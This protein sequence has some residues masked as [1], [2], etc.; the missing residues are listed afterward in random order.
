MSINK[1]KFFLN[2]I[3]LESE[4]NILIFE[5]IDQNNLKKFLISFKNLPEIEN[6]CDKSKSKLMEEKLEIFPEI[7]KIIRFDINKFD[8]LVES[9]LKNEINDCKLRYKFLFIHIITYISNKKYEHFN[10]ITI[11]NKKKV[12]E[13]FD[14]RDERRYFGKYVMEK[15][16]KLFF[17]KVNLNFKIKHPKNF[18]SE[19]ENSK[20]LDLKLCVPL[21]LLYGYLKVKYSLNLEEVVK[22]LKTYSDKDL[23]RISNWF[24]SKLKTN[25]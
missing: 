4:S 16:F 13:R 20:E 19:K 8:F 14:T 12:I 15:F 9:K 3:L 25:F 10:L 23:F 21:S 5:K 24:L 18:I 6:L 11:D 2:D 22:L 17:E 7:L 1:A